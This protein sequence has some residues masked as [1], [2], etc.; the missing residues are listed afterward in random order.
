VLEVRRFAGG[1][2]QTL[3][4]PFDEGL[5]GE[6]GPVRIPAIHERMRRL[7]SQ[8]RLG[9][10]P[11]AST[12][13]ASLVSVG[14]SAA[15]MPDQLKEIASRLHLE[16]AE[17]GLSPNALLQRY[18][19]ELPSGL[20]RLDP[21]AASYEGWKDLDR[22][23]WPEW[24]RS[25]G[26]SPGAVTLMTL[27]GDSRT[28][29]ALYVLRQYVLLQN[30][31]Q[32]FKIDGGMDQLPRAMAAALGRRLR[33]GVAVTR[34]T[35]HADS[36]D[37]E[38]VEGGRT[39]TIRGSRIVITLPFSTL[40][41]VRTSPV[42]SKSKV[43][44]I[45]G[46]RYFPATRLLLQTKSR[47][48]HEAGLSASVRTDDPAEIWDASYDSPAGRGLL[49]VTVGGEIGRKLE[50]LERRAAVEFGV[51][52]VAKALPA[53]KG[54]FE[55]GVVYRWAM[56]PWSRGAFAVFQPGEMTS[57]MPELARPEG[58]IHFAGEHTSSWM[59]W[60][61]GALE[62]GERAAKEVLAAT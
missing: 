6:L 27:G 52:L 44:A 30:A 3:R 31:T 25:K 16:P 4:A 15:R 58:R 53:L 54:Q 1:R 22:V 9:L 45:N 14:G 24:I 13:G 39:T 21:D 18:V 47:F 19:K 26:A 48:W 57:M 7:T 8:Y 60:M 41:D 38:C 33:Y 42:F 5:H 12:I 29:S 34:V 2:V 20:E 36:V 32:S 37:L 28:L 62:S 56:D 17:A 55:K 43:Q 51:T 59:G 11:Y 49:G 10:V 50:T 23:S 35:Q 46:L 40:K 61:E